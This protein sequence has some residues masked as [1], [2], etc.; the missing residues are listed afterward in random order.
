MITEETDLRVAIIKERVRSIVHQY[1]YYKNKGD[2]PLLRELTKKIKGWIIIGD[3]Y[4]DW[5]NN[6][7]IEFD[8]QGYFKIDIN[9][10]QG[11]DKGIDVIFSNEFKTLSYRLNNGIPLNE[12]SDNPL[13]NITNPDN[14]EHIFYSPSRLVFIHNDKNLETFCFPEVKFTK[15]YIKNKDTRYDDDIINILELLP[16]DE[17]LLIITNNINLGY[18]K[19]SKLNIVKGI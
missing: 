5:G 3:K 10:Y 1:I 16:R 2:N 11:I 14:L 4:R 19:N 15:N 18:Y 8:Q 6:I 7:I 17:D 9:I 12:I 13:R